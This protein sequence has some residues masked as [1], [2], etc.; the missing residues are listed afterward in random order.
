MNNEPFLQGP[1]LITTPRRYWATAGRGYSVNTL[2]RASVGL[3][4]SV[5]STVDRAAY[6]A[7][8]PLAGIP[9]GQIMRSGPLSPLRRRGWPML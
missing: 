6:A 9:F 2:A 1:A 8:S 4:V 3:P 5:R 7:A